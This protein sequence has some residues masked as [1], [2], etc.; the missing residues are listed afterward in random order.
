MNINKLRFGVSKDPYC[1]SDRI[2]I[3]IG[4]FRSHITI[5]TSRYCGDIPVIA[6]GAAAEQK[7]RGLRSI[8]IRVFSGFVIG[9][10][11]FRVRTRRRSFPRE[12]PAEVRIPASRGATARRCRLRPS[13]PGFFH[14]GIT[15]LHTEKVLLLAVFCYDTKTKRFYISLIYRI[16][17]FMLRNLTQQ[18][19]SF[20][21]GPRER[22]TELRPLI[23]VAVYQLFCKRTKS[24]YHTLALREKH[25]FAYLSIE[26]FNPIQRYNN[27]FILC[28]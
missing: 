11:P 8:D 9:G 23:E 5:I 7:S 17:R 22:K 28:G 1:V 10:E 16:I 24:L 2:Y 4:V 26:L 27:S 13:A 19:R 20:I 25:W 12:L 3:T 14:R 18:K 6:S 15:L 21:E